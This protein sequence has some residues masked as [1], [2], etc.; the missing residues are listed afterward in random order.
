M[1]ENIPYNKKV[2]GLVVI[3][4]ML[5]IAAYK[6]SFSLTIGAYQKLNDLQDRLTY[7]NSSNE[8]YSMISQEIQILDELIGKKGIDPIRVQQELLDFVSINHNN[9]V[10]IVDVA[11]IHESTNKDFL[12]YTNQ[13]TL[14]GGY[15][16]LLEVIASFETDF[17][18]SRLVS[19]AFDKKK[20]YKNK[21]SVLNANLIFQNYEKK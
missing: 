6:R 11:K 3:T 8:D 15:Q 9:K 16:N 2:I 14:K 12:V 19:I 13:L 7:I 18:Y 4:I 1:F 17:E 10:S 21:K 5:S 20:N